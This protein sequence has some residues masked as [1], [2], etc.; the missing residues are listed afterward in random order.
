LEIRRIQTKYFAKLQ[1]TT[2]S[3]ANETR[4]DLRRRNIKIGRGA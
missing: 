3:Q 1:P 2:P 4:M